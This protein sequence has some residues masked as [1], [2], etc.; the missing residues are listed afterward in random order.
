M[1]PSPASPLAIRR[2]T[3][4]LLRP[5]FAAA[6]VLPAIAGPAIRGRGRGDGVVAIMFL[7]VP[8]L[9]VLALPLCVPRAGH[10]DGA[11]IRAS[12][13]PTPSPRTTRAPT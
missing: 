6:W 3:V 4:D 9:A 7:A 13:V 12:P 5:G 1:T 11:A 2:T 8:L 10:A